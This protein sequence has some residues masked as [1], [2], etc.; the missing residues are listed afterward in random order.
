MCAGEA[1]EGEL[2]FFFLLANRQAAPTPSKHENREAHPGPI[3]ASWG[4]SFCIDFPDMRALDL[5]VV[6]VMVVLAG[7]CGRGLAAFTCAT[8]LDCG[9]LGACVAKGCQCYKGYTGDGNQCD[10]VENNPPTHP[11]W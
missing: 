1:E 5:S 2:L 11:C 3:A 4:L 8:D 9:L 10:N 6:M 7:C